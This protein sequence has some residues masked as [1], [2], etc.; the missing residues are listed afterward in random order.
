MG[1]LKAIGATDG[2]VFQ[3]FIFESVLFGLLGIVVGVGLSQAM[4]GAFARNPIPVPIGGGV[5]PDVRPELLAQGAAAVLG[6]GLLAAYYPAWR[7]AR[8]PI[9]QSIWG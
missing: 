3:L 4:A 1:V 2:V 9:V 6:A 7:A 5:V 8:H